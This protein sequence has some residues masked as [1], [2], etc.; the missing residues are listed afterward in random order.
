MPD[1]PYLSTLN[2]DPGLSRLFWGV[3]YPSIVDRILKSISF[4]YPT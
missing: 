4:P 3:I 2:E 1:K